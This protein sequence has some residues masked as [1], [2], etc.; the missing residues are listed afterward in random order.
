MTCIK[1]ITAPARVKAAGDNAE[2]GTFVAIVSVFGNV[3]TYGDVVASGA[4]TETLA[5]WAASGDPI[6]VVWSHE[7][8]D[9]DSHI[10]V[11]LDAIETDEGLQIT[12]QLDL[13]EP[14]S[15]KVF[16]LLKERRVTQFSFAYEVREGAWAERDGREVY[17]LRR[18]GLIEVGPTLVGVNSATRLLDAKSE[19][20]GAASKIDRAALAAADT[21]PP[22]P[23]R[24][25]SRAA[26]SA[27]LA[28]LNPTEEVTQ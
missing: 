24:A 1:R 6:P 28:L 20:D 26:V 18:L 23:G 25:K 12:G 17:E 3:D 4:F 27:C 5:E 22:I 16:R 11:V 21:P 8:N 10:G 9:P 15:S 13:D 14:K 19:S 2:A 7:W